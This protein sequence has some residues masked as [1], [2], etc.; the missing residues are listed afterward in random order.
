MLGFER[1]VPLA[2]KRIP[3]DVQ[4]FHLLTGHLGDQRK[5]AVIQFN[6]DPHPGL[7]VAVAAIMLTIT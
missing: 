4:L 1:L 5:L 3:A 2:V 6:L 7:G